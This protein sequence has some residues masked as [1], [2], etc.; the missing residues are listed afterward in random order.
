MISY[1]KS[2]YHRRTLVFRSFIIL[3]FVT[4]CLVFPINNCFSKSYADCSY[5]RPAKINDGWETASIYTANIDAEKLITLIRHIRSE[6]YKNIHGILIVKEGK[7]ILEEYFHG[8]NR[9]KPHQIRSATKS[10]GSILTGI[11]IDHGFI[12]DVEERIYPYVKEYETGQKWDARVRDITLKSLLTMTSGFACDDHATPR[13]QCEEAMYE[14][15]DWVKYALNLPVAHKPGEHWAYNSSSLILVS[16]FISKTS[17]MTLPD[18]ADTYLF[19]PLGIKDFHWGFS[20]KG[21]A[22]IAGNAKM[23]PRDMAKIGLL[24]L[25]S[26]RWKGK[27]IISE[28]WI[29]ESTREHERSENNWGYGYLWWMG[30]QLFGEQFISGYWA[31]GNGGNYIFVCPALDLVAVFTGGNYNSIVE[32][33]TLGMLTNYIIPA[34]LPPS[35]PRESISLDPAIL[36]SYVGEYQLQQGHIRVSVFKKNDA[37]YCTVLERTMPMYPETEDRF[38]IPDDILGNWTFKTERNEKGV[39]TSAT[40]YTAFQVMPFAKIK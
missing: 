38:F 17:T 4:A 9:E 23:K 29:S 32:L 37:L 24:M 15:D 40:G 13:F 14:T 11:A 6:R 1:Q 18:F 10:I 3:F 36:D 35:K 20:P 33:Q 12:K 21:R 39:A 16:E 5:Q 22:W 34:I 8:F 7:L 30:K 26:G 27:Q 28:K 31:A 25:N 19:V 2:K